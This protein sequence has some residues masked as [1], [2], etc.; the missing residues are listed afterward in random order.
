MLL[1]VV[2]FAGLVDFKS[3]RLSRVVLTSE[4]LY[5]ILGIM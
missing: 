2:S 3:L 1:G 5:I 4:E